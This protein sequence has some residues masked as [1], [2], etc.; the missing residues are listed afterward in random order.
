VILLPTLTALTLGLLRTSTELA[1]ADEFNRTVTQVDLS[2]TVEQLVHDIQGERDLVVS[3][4]AAGRVGDRSAVAAQIDVVNRSMTRV[5][6]ASDA[7]T[8]L[9]EA[10]R[11]RYDK[12]V[13][14]LGTVEA[15]RQLAEQ[16]LFPASDAQFVYD[17][18][19]NSLLQ[20]NREVTRVSDDRAISEQAARFD[21]IAGAKEQLAI[22]NSIL[23]AAALSNW[24]GPGQLARLRSAQAEFTAELTAFQEAADPATL[25]RY[26]NT[27]AGP[28][29]DDRL[30][31]L[32]N[33]INQ[34]DAGEPV[35]INIQEL[36]AAARITLNKMRE[37]EQ[38]SLRD[39]RATAQRLAETA[40]TNVVRDALLIGVV[41]LL[42]LVFMLV[43]ARSLLKPLRV[44][45]RHALNAAHSRLPAT[46]QRIL[47]DSNPLKASEDAVDPVP[48]RTTEEVGQVARAIDTLQGEAVRLA[49][50]HAL[51]RDNIN[52][53]FVNLSRRN[54]NLVQRQ[55]NLIDKLEQDEQDPDQLAHLFQLD[56][57]ATRMRRYCESLLVLSGTAQSRSINQLVSASDVVAAAQSEVE[58]YKR[59]EVTAAPEVSV[60]GRVVSD[61][62]H[63]LAE[64]LDNATQFSN[65]DTTVV[66]R[67][68]VS[69]KR[70]LVIQILDKGIGMTE[71]EITSANQRLASPPDLD[72]RVTKRMGLY[73]VA[74]L[75]KRHNI[76][77]ELRENEDIEEGLI[78]RI[79][80]PNQLITLH[81][82]STTMT[83]STN[84][85]ANRPQ[86]DSAAARPARAFRAF[87]R[88]PRTTSTAPISHPTAAVEAPVVVEPSAPG[89]GQ[90]PGSPW[91]GTGDTDDTS[92]GPQTERLPIYEAVLSQWFSTSADSAV[93]TNAPATDRRRPSAATH[94]ERPHGDGAAV[95]SHG[96]A[97]S[98]TSGGDS[99]WQ[100][101]KTVLHGTIDAT[102]AAGLPKRVPK[103][104]LMPGSATQRDEDREKHRSSTTKPVS[105]AVPQRSAHVVRARMASYQ[106]GVRRG[107][108]VLVSS[109]AD[110]N[111]HRSERT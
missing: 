109:P 48:V 69:R 49:T 15:I 9:D 54:Q 99:G 18:I 30:R 19:I 87:G 5:R 70:E 53:I 82:T 66:V 71:E 25:S 107:R 91:A 40:Q 93:D 51:L 7:I 63:L 90:V 100:A 4:V 36:D 105:V 65:P 67:M 16:T 10:V 74:R 64:L 110:T 101:V 3:R 62:M 88:R 102:T 44:L 28:E 21:A 26:T 59:I 80:V 55:L 95:E 56:H 92:D 50:E 94:P 35:T 17:S 81:P 111:D 57:L 38:A 77:V 37:V 83:S 33:A 58:Q 98:W 97:A 45:R 52:T 1:N 75:A 47:A 41:L 29:V 20:L 60:H 79:A 61:L 46:V 42:A 23:R 8:N 104:R 32:Q 34:G 103:A 39:L 31:L 2:S 14:G 73:V 89:T 43:V 78:A 12:V 27:V 11:T 24:F 108:H 13:A 84:L 22:Q 68:Q 106:E 72:V 76:T 96:D 6:A 85:S 86:L